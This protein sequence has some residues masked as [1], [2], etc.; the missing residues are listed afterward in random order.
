[1]GYTGL[2]R[3]INAPTTS[4]ELIHQNIIRNHQGQYRGKWSLSIRSYRSTLSSIPGYQVHAER[5]MCT[6]TMNDNVFVLLEDPAAPMHSEY[7]Q[8]AA[9]L[10]QSQ[11]GVALPPPAHY[12]HTFPT[13]SPP[14]ALEQLLAQ[15][16]ARWVSVRQSAGGASA[17]SASAAAT[18]ATATTAVAAGG[19]KGQGT[20]QQLTVEGH[21]YAI[22]TDWLVRAGNVLLAGGAVKGMFLEAEYLPLP[23]M[24]TRANERGETD[25]QF[26]LSNLLLSVLPNVPDARIVA[27]TIG[28]A[29]WEEIL[30]E[31][32]DEDEQ[33]AK[34]AQ[35]G[36]D[37]DDDDDDDIYAKDGDLPAVRKGDWIGVERD[38]RSAFLI[39]G[40]LKQEGLL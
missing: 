28:D 38:R 22:G 1:M 2:A 34:P 15:L 32:P 27:V 29:Q 26:L 31:E 23:T 40:A 12:R 37:D 24:P 19:Q 7:Q 8:K 10:A 36:Q 25:L 4:I 30:W 14:G 3:W 33:K 18:A 13:L 17:A 16:R 11:P 6:L 9:E 5:S 39:I 20:G 21:V 35:G